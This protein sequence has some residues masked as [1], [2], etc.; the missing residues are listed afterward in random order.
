VKWICAADKEQKSNKIS[1]RQLCQGMN[2]TLTQLCAG[3]DFIEFFHHESFKT[4]KGQK[5]HEFLYIVQET[6]LVCI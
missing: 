1:G 5:L 6:E 2:H 3:E 4:K